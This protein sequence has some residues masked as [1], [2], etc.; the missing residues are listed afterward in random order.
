VENWLSL[1]IQKAAD[2]AQ[3]HW[4]LSLPIISWSVSGPKTL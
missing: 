2:Y 1:A 3:V 4:S